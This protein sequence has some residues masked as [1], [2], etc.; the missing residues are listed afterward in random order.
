M[1]SGIGE[2]IWGRG[3]GV[4]H[5]K[6]GLDRGQNLGQDLSRRSGMSGVR[7]RHLGREW[8]LGWSMYGLRDK[9]ERGVV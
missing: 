4:L 9:S 8:G 6:R 2:E 3:R 7:G 5:R 1:R